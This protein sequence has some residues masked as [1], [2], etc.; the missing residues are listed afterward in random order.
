M[1]ASGGPA[2]AG[3]GRIARFAAAAALACA[4]A[5]CGGDPAGEGEPAASDALLAEVGA[6][7]DSLERHLATD[8]LFRPVVADTSDVLIRIAFPVVERLV[9]DATRAYLDEVRLH[10]EPD[11]V[12]REGDEVRVRVGPF[13]VKAGEWSVRVTI[14][15]IEGRLRADSVHLAVADSARLAL[16]VPVRVEDGAGR[17]SIDFHWDAA[18]VGSV[19]CR[20]FE[21]HETFS[22]VVAP[23]TYDLQGTVTFATEG[24]RF[25]ARPAQ[26]GERLVVSPEPTPAA[27]ERVRE[28][29]DRQNNIFRCGL[30]LQPDDMEALLRRLLRRGFRFRLPD[31]ILEPIPL[32]ASVQERVSLDGRE[33]RLS[34]HPTTLRST[35]AALWYGVRVE[36]GETTGR[37]P[38]AAPPVPDSGE[39]SRP[40]P[41]A[42]GPS[43]PPATSPDS[44]P[45]TPM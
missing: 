35:P 19:V 38:A 6:L 2:G 33:L 39:P 15:R 11:L 26:T 5:G 9:Q 25:L 42:P 30:A 7:R 31:A 36:A 18:G 20:D 1:R 28:L 37:P 40:V 8:S 21:A 34:V 29:L 14:H 17:A 3:G 32:P 23:R 4:A 44:A 12:V 43:P 22:G 41:Y 16:R 10:L 13:D 24:D 27:W 45:T